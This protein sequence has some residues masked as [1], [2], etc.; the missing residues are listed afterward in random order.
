MITKYGGPSNIPDAEYPEVDTFRV[1][2]KTKRFKTESSIPNG[3][4]SDDSL[5][6]L[7]I[8]LIR[9]MDAE[10]KKLIKQSFPKVNIDDVI[11]LEDGR[12][13]ASMM[14]S[15]GMIGGGILLALAGLA[16]MLSGFRS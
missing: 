4:S 9:S 1:L 3:I 16:W 13:P 14:V 10:E 8:N 7:V 15:L 5:K 2:V 12:E 6:G 11:I